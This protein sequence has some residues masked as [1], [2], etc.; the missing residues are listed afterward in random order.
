MRGESEQLSIIAS[1]TEQTISTRT[2]TVNVDDSST[3]IQAGLGY[4]HKLYHSVP[5]TVVNGIQLHW[6]NLPDNYST[7]LSK[8]KSYLVSIEGQKKTS[9]S[10]F[11]KSRY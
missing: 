5:L 6:G 10:N 8:S 1:S 9:I 4:S 2:A 3:V 11:I 7:K